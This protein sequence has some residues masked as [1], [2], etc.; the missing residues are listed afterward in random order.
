MTN[1]YLFAADAILI[2]HSLVVLFIIMGLLTIIIGGLLEWNW[3]K[4]RWF[5]LL[6]LLA[7]VVVVVQAWLGRICPLTILEMWLRQQAGELSY[8]V[9]F[10]QYWLQRLLYYDF[11]LWVF[12]AAYTLFGLAVIASWFWFPPNPKTSHHSE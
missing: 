3:I 7:I 6:H 11:P 2:L 5:R 8:E 9:S 1:F 12:A 10:V 4:K